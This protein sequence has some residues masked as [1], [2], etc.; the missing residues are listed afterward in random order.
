ML[1]FPAH[2]SRICLLPSTL[3]FP[4]WG[5]HTHSSCQCPLF[6]SVWLTVNTCVF[7]LIEVMSMYRFAPWASSSLGLWRPVQS[8]GR[9]GV[10]AACSCVTRLRHGSRPLPLWRARRRFRYGFCL[11]AVTV[12]AAG[13]IRGLLLGPVRRSLCIPG[14]GV[15][16][17]TQVA[18]QNHFISVVPPA[19][20]R[21]HIPCVL[22]QTG[23]V[24][25]VDSCQLDG[26]K[27]YLVLISKTGH[28]LM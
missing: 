1:W 2:P 3:P 6:R 17:H 11:V 22:T 20:V 28:W 9:V 16:L 4:S 26:M 14:S 19:Y 7:T 10:T 23:L 8:D 27:W 18:F 13:A 12:G 15:R 21:V 24:R 5:D 25:H